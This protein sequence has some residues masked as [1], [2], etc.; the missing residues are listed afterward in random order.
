MKYTLKG[1][2]KD[3]VNNLMRKIS[4]TFQGKDENQ[5][6]L[7]F[8]RPA[9][10]YPRFHIYAKYEND[11]LFINLHLDQKRPVYQ[12][13]SAHSGEYEGEVVEKEMARIKQMLESY[14]QTE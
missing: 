8:I 3:N 1:P 7:S 4:Y 13:V 10:A 6:D 9:H 11:S 14:A 5:G 2:L 12:G